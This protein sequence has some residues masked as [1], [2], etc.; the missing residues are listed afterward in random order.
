MELEHNQRSEEEV[1]AAIAHFF[2][3][4]GRIDPLPEKVLHDELEEMLIEQG[5]D[6]IREMVV[7][8]RDRVDL[9]IVPNDRH[10]LR[11]IIELKTADPIRG[12]G[13][14][15][16]YQV[17][18]P[19]FAHRVLVID[20]EV[21]N[22]QVARACAVA[23]IE[24][25]AYMAEEF[26]HITGP[27]TL[28]NMARRSDQPEIEYESFKPGPVETCPCCEGSV[29]VPSETA[30]ELVKQYA[31]PENKIVRISRVWR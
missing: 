26:R 4:G 5:F 13:Q 23:E 14:V 22:G 24:L 9:A 30:K 16:S 1:E 31:P 25:W 12:V 21:L 29:R 2:A 20:G 15:L 8:P 28:W 10:D 6:T 18:V 27:P 17:G 3:N 19:E 11:A 7:K